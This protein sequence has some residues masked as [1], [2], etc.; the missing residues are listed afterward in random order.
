MPQ[1]ETAGSLASQSAHT[2]ETPES[3]SSMNWL[4]LVVSMVL[5]AAL[6]VRRLQP[7]AWQRLQ[8]AGNQ[9]CLTVWA[10]L[11]SV[12]ILQICHRLA[13][14]AVVA[15]L[16]F[17]AWAIS[18][19]GS[20]FARGRS[21][22]DEQH[23]P[24]EAQSLLSE[25]SSHA[26]DTHSG[27]SVGVASARRTL[28]GAIDAT[29]SLGASAPERPGAPAADGRE[30]QS[31]LFSQLSQVAQQATA[32]VAALAADAG[33]GDRSP[34]LHSGPDGRFA[35][36][37]ARST[38][39]PELR[40]YP[41]DLKLVLNAQSLKLI[42]QHLPRRCQGSNWKCIFHTHADGYSLPTLYR[43]AARYPDTVLVV[44]GKSGHTVAA[45]ASRPWRPQRHFFGTG[46]TV[47]FALQPHAVEYKWTQN[48]KLFQLAKP[49]ALALGGGGDGF[50]LYLNDTLQKGSSG[51]CDT[52]GNASSLLGENQCEI[53]C[54]ELWAL[55]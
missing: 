27:G 22:T 9:A 6:L 48:N 17:V 32:A 30:G 18:Q 36:G 54:V 52:F 43:K 15:F 23:T 25:Q 35:S 1:A 2:N 20:L 49:S 7:A 26:E 3:I 53:I 38:R 39:L 13:H 42:L 21:S 8:A 44:V 51:G 11:P 29:D 4:F 33:G 50:A 47:L 19:R 10:R 14:R 5:C 31:S 45:F 46:E 41:A 24:D 12:A 40:G 16:N 55:C 28:S 34:P 37:G